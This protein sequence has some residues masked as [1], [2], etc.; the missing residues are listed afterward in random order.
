MN[1][2]VKS[3]RL[4]SGF[5]NLLGKSAGNLVYHTVRF[6]LRILLDLIILP[7]FSMMENIRVIAWN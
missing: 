5:C 1:I 6:M 4:F 7:V 2:L 3:V